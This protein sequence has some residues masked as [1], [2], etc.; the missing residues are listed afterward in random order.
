M[1][2]RRAGPVD[3]A[4]VRQRL[5][6]AEEALS[7]GRDADPDQ[8]R[9]VLEA[10]ARAL[11]A[12]SMPAAEAADDIELVEFELGAE[13]YAIDAD[14]VREVETLKELTD[15][16]CTPGHVSGIMNAHGRIIAV[17]DLKRFFERPE[18]GL[19]DLNKVVILQLRD[20]EFGILADRIIGTTRVGLARLHAAS[21]VIGVALKRHL[22]GVTAGGT[23]VLDARGLASDPALMVDQ[24][25]LP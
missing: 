24:E 7:R 2:T 11:A 9:A 12:E 13:R 25:V 10:R 1:K 6:R 21:T 14:C 15:V 4:Q 16:P 23:W 17:I 20:I 8:R 19:S 3:W 18:S 22:R 5:A